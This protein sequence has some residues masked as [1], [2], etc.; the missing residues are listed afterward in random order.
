M[1]KEDQKSFYAR[2]G[3]ALTDARKR[4][5]M[6]IATLSKQSG[7][8]YKTIQDIEAGRVCS[9]HH[10]VWMSRVL[11]IDINEIAREGKQSGIRIEDII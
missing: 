6:S 3:R 11:G 4:R 1:N 5:N 9:L 8:Q 7:E 10:V 2:V